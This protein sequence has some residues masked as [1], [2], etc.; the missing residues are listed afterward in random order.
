MANSF[1]FLGA[2]GKTRVLF[3]FELRPFGFINFLIFDHV[4]RK[5][6]ISRKSTSFQ[7]FNYVVNFE[8]AAARIIDLLVEI[9]IL[10][11]LSKRY[12][13]SAPLFLWS[14]SNFLGY[15]VSF[16]AISWSLVMLLHR[17]L[18]MIIIIRRSKRPQ[19]VIIIDDLAP[20]FFQQVQVLSFVLLQH[21]IIVLVQIHI[22]NLLGFRS[23]L[24]ASL[25]DQAEVALGSAAGRI[26]WYVHFQS[27]E[28][29]D[30]VAGIT[31]N[32]LYVM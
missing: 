20:C 27:L 4:V 3:N 21:L 17:L 28:S 14:L 26:V 11:G 16:T 12:A 7:L 1:A 19:K 32:H 18:Q 15:Q 5:L 13:P 10:L 29:D 6:A 24:L 8:L 22:Q 2:L 25:E 31:F 23:L 30:D 9:N